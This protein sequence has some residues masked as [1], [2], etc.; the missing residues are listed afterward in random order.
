MQTKADSILEALTNIGIGFVVA[1]CA[2]LIWFPLI[3]KEFTISENLA[4][5]SFFTFVSF[6]R[7]YCIRRMFN[8]RSIY[9]GIKRA[10]QGAA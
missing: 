9:Q 1:L 4:T 2:Q 5:T 8:G 3:G 6:A 10:I 7:S